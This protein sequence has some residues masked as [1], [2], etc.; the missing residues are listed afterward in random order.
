MS[1]KRIAQ[2]ALATSTRR[3]DFRDEPAMTDNLMEIGTRRIFDEDH[4]QYR[5]MVRKWFA[6]ECVPH[7]AAW[8]ETGIVPREIWE[9]A[10]ENGLLG[11][12]TPEELGGIGA[13]RLHAAIVWEEQ[14]YSNCS[15]PGFA[16]HSDICMPYIVNFGTD[17]QKTRFLPEMTAGKCISAIAMTEP[18]AGSDLQGMRTNAKRDGDDWILNGSKTFITNGQNADLTLVCAITNP[19]AKN[20]AHGISI[21]LVETGMEGFKKGNNLKK[22]GMK[23]QDTSELFFEDVRLPMSSILG[24][25]EG[26]NQGFFMLMKELP[27]ERLLI[28]DMSVA[29]A[30]MMYEKTRDYILDRKA[31]GAPIAKMQLIRHQMAELKTNITI[32]RA[33]TDQCIELHNIGKLNTSMASMNKYAMTELE[34]NVA[35]RCVQLHGGWGY[36]WEYDVCR[37]FVDARVQRIYGGTNEIMKEIISRDISKRK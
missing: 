33:F 5:E 24:G 15:G 22:M 25:E 29:K 18:G 28:G 17:E 3:R 34:G 6:N 36:M 10:G 1:F 23:A 26:M 21:F 9:S 19:E 11:A 27:Q 12:Q 37:A 2:R 4:D 13:D 32:G 30:E 8:E 7:H 35:D 31:F 20:P 16:L 14:S